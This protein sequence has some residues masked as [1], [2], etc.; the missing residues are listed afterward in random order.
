MGTLSKA[1]DDLKGATVSRRAD[2]PEAGVADFAL[3]S[4]SLATRRED[5]SPYLKALW[6][7]VRPVEGDQA[8]GDEVGTLHFKGV[9]KTT[10]EY[11]ARETKELYLTLFDAS[12]SDS[13]KV[14]T[15]IRRQLGLGEDADPWKTVAFLS[16]G[17]ALD[18]ETKTGPGIFDRNV[19]VR[20]RTTLSP[21]KTDVPFK[22]YRYLR[23]VPVKEVIDGLDEDKMKEAFG[24][25][26]HAIELAESGK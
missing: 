17:L 12:P 7:C 20:I 11:F 6:V 1:F 16:C 18:G 22:N 14:E 21:S 15:D 5:E 13:A 19:V 2:T 3:Q 8:V 4:I 9:S 23:R 24:T 25:V 10:K 26:E